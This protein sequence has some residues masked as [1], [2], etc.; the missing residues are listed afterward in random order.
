MIDYLT[1]ADR[2]TTKYLELVGRGRYT[3][4]VT[5]KQEAESG[6][7]AMVAQIT[8]QVTKN[9]K[10]SLKAAQAKQSAKPDGQQPSEGDTRVDGTRR[11]VDD[12]DLN[13][14]DRT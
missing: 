4:A 10:D 7:V 9:I 2:S 8:K 5:T 1:L 3:P 13:I 6:P 14:F 12:F 11:E